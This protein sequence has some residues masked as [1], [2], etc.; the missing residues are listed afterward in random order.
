MSRF[1]SFPGL[2]A[3][4][5]SVL[6]CT[7]VGAS[8]APPDE[9]PTEERKP[10]KEAPQPSPRKEEVPTAKT[11]PDPSP[12]ADPAPRTEP[13]PKTEPG[14]EPEVEPEFEPEVRPSKQTPRRAPRR[15]K[16]TRP[17]M[18]KEPPP[19]DESGAPLPEDLRQGVAD[20][21]PPINDRLLPGFPKI[22]EVR[23]LHLGDRRPAPVVAPTPSPKDEP[24]GPSLW[25]RLTERFGS[26]RT[27]VNVIVLAA[28]VV[29]FGLYRLRAGR[30][31]YP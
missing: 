3:L 8:A 20:A 12:K 11:D 31:R 24:Q 22:E 30:S 4:F 13:A 27:L 25:D 18:K 14:R 23:Y 29:I 6:L 5:L 28:L 15:E 9:G 1:G 10:K 17:V 2:S 16:E 26:D 19:A 7:V 21:F